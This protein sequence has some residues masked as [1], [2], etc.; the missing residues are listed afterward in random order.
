M[1]EIAR[2]VWRR[3]R[4]AGARAADRT[5]V[6]PNNVKARRDKLWLAAQHLTDLR[7]G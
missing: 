7:G 2:S 3:R 6:R 1:S 4:A 5:L